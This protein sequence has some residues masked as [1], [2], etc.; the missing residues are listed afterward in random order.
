MTPHFHILGLGSWDH[1][2]DAAGL[3]TATRIAERGLSSISVSLDTARGARLL[4]LVH[5]HV[6]TLILHAAIAEPKRVG[7][8][9]KV[10]YPHDVAEM[11]EPSPEEQRAFSVRE[12]LD[13]AAELGRLPRHVWVYRLGVA[14]IAAWQAESRDL[15]EA[16][17]HF[18][19]VV[20]EDIDTLTRRPP[21][22]S[23][24]DRLTNHPYFT[25]DHAAPVTGHG[26]PNRLTPLAGG[27]FTAA[28]AR[29]AADEALMGSFRL[30]F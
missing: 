9:H 5:S 27:R 14:D 6:P 3:L 28:Q 13:L 30:G 19:S 22:L 25:A 24:A 23:A 21:R 20:L 4:D 18:V 8:V 17:P 26:L 10:R 16:V 12:M 7:T 15:V 29:Q 11:A 2:D 1:G